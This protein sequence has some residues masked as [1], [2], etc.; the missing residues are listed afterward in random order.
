MRSLLFIASGLLLKSGLD[1]TQLFREG[2]HDPEIENEI[3][4][5]NSTH[6]NDRLYGSLFINPA[7]LPRFRRRRRSETDAST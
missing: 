1:V 2:I 4:N 6:E 7:F 5:K 3:E